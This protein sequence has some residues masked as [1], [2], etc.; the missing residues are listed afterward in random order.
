MGDPRN[1]PDSFESSTVPVDTRNNAENAFQAFRGMSQEEWS[2]LI[3]SLM[4]GGVL[5]PAEQEG[6]EKAMRERPRCSCEGNWE[7]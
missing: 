1:N 3:A 2:G 4:R 5:S 6:F 7:F